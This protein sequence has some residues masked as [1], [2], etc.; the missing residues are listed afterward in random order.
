MIVRPS[1][2]YTAIPDEPLSIFG[3]FVT[4][5]I[6]EWDVGQTDDFVTKQFEVTAQSLFIKSLIE[7]DLRCRAVQ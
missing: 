5:Q 7:G 6:H 4:R 3:A 2:S 1:K